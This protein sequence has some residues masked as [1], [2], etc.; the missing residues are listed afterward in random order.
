MIYLSKKKREEQLPDFWKTY[1]HAF[2]EKLPK[3]ITDTCFVVLDTETTG[4]D[5]QKDRILCMGA[6]RLQNHQIK[7]KES[8]EVYLDQEH[9]D[10]ASAHVHGLLQQE[11]KTQISEQEAIEQFLVYIKNKV[12][13]GHH[14]GFDV[15]MIN[16]MLKRTGLPKLLNHVLDTAELYRRTLLPTPILYKKANYSLDDL[17]RKFSIPRKDRHTALGDAYIT[18][19]AFLEILEQLKP[20]KMTN[21]LKKPKNSIF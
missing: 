17:A 11:K 12:L 16:Q 14:I 1:A 18:A 6:L 10:V 2:E 5:Y 15:E 19:I 20:K 8:F 3:D 7:V 21:L 13:V 9:Y 4:F